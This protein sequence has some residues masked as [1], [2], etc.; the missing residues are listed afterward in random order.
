MFNITMKL[1]E[2]SNKYKSQ[3]L[4]F[5]TEIKNKN[6]KKS[7][8]ELLNE[9][10]NITMI[11]SL[12][13][14]KEYKKISL[15]SETFNKIYKK[16]NQNKSNYILSFNKFIKDIDNNI[17]LDK[18]EINENKI[19]K[20]SIQTF[21]NITSNI[22]IYD[23][24]IENVLNEANIN[25]P[26]EN[27]LGNPITSNIETLK[28]F[29]NWFGD[30]KIK[31]NQNRPIIMYHGSLSKFNKFNTS[32]IDF[33]FEEE[34]AYNYANQKSFEG[35]Y[36]ESPIIYKCYIK[37]E[38]PFDFRNNEHLSLLKNKLGNSTIRTSGTHHSVDEFIK[39]LSG[40]YTIRSINSDKMNWED[41]KIGYYYSKDNEDVVVNK[42][43]VNRDDIIYKS[44]DFFLATDLNRVNDLPY[45][46][47]EHHFELLEDINSIKDKI[48]KTSLKTDFSEDKVAEI[49]IPLKYNIVNNT[50]YH[51]YYYEPEKLKEK[52]KEVEI[53]IRFWVYKVENPENAETSNTYDNWLQFESSWIDDENKTDISDIIKSLGFDGYYMQ[54]GGQLNLAIFNS[55]QAKVITNKKFSKKTNNI[56]ES[57]TGIIEDITDEE[58]NYKDK[59][60][61][62]INI[63]KQELLQMINDTFFKELRAFYHRAE[64]KLYCWDASKAIH[65]NI[66]KSYG[67]SINDLWLFSIKKDGI[68]VRPSNEI[69]AIL[70]NFDKFS[71]FA[72]EIDN[73]PTL[74]NYFPNKSTY[75]NM[76]IDIIRYKK[77]NPEFYNIF[78][79]EKKPVEDE[80]I[81]IK[82]KYN[83]KESIKRRYSK[84]LI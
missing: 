4:F 16:F 18:P 76:I 47:K 71:E 61:V 10:I 44:N 39:N 62:G 38:N 27:N 75:D 45:F 13:K 51:I 56:D 17:I 84:I 2:L 25:L 49:Y 40:V 1:S 14:N 73:T 8:N 77:L 65:E 19:I 34:F 60:E 63:S 35:G 43:S 54:E 20:K 3:N 67:L 30:S 22:P 58:I 15:L 46:Y 50:F 68:H 70:K 52:Y 23:N 26:N 37:C 74:T 29:W 41:I 55:K 28:K 66:A 78:L 24:L 53:P 72:K 48:I 7:I 69:D 12:I 31:D 42:S 80:I 79:I 57:N 11:K 21:N 32:T 5:N 9:N 81:R 64:D 6:V 83:L 82:E 59:I 33:S 36:D